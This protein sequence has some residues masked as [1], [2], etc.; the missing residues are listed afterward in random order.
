VA[1]NERL[2]FAVALASTE[3]TT[4]LAYISYGLVGGEAASCKRKARLVGAVGRTGGQNP[5]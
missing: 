2:A 4:P 1:V 3:E 5:Q